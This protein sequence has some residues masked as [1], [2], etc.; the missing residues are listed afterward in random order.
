MQQNIKKIARYIRNP[1]VIVL[2]ITLL[3]AITIIAIQPNGC[4]ELNCLLGPSGIATA[5]SSSPTLLAPASSKSSNNVTLVPKVSTATINVPLKTS[6][7]TATLEPDKVLALLNDYDN[8]IA[9]L[10]EMMQNVEFTQP[11]P[12]R[13]DYDLCPNGKVIITNFF[14]DSRK[15][16]QYDLNCLGHFQVAKFEAEEKDK[17]T[18]KVY[19]TDGDRTANYLRLDSDGNGQFDDN[20][21]CTYGPD[22][23]W[24]PLTLKGVPCTFP[25]FFGAPVVIPL[26]FFYP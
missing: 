22:N 14:H 24:R 16:T 11:E 10:D 7:P 8:Q 13:E 17:I 21:I 23:R 9:G 4:Q 12:F 5:I 25:K 26:V 6:A 1:V 19:D 3:S 20:E 2:A 15:L 18:Y